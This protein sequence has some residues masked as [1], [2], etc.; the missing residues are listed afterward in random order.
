MIYLYNTLARKKQIFKPIKNKQVG[1]YTCGP[2][3]YSYAHIGNLRTYIFED[4]LKRVLFYH[5]YKVKHVMNITD[6]GHLT[7][8]ADTGEDKIEKA[9]K[10]SKKSA[11][12]IA[13]F[14]T[15]TFFTDCEKLN[16]LAPDIIAKA[17]DHIEEDIELIKELERKNFT[18]KTSDGIYF[19][20]SK[21]KDYGKLTG[22]NFTK[23]N[24]T[25]M[26]GARI[27][28]SQEKKNITDFS[29]WKFSPKNEKR[30]M[31]WKSPWGIG[32]PGWHIECSAINLKY[33]G[34]AFKGKK[35][36]LKKAQTIDIH[37]GGTDHIPIHHT[38]EIAQVEAVTNKQFVNFWLHGEFLVL[39][40][41]RMGKSE[42][43][44]I[45]IKNIEESGFSPIA[46]RYLV[47]N[48][49]YRTLLEFSEKSLKNA[50]ESLNNIYNFVL[51]CLI[52][53]KSNSLTQSNNNIK[54]KKNIDSLLNKIKK[55]FETSINDD[56]NTPKALAVFW[57]LIKNYYEFKN[58]S[59]KTSKVFLKRIYA[60]AMNFDKILGLKLDKIKLTTI[61]KKIKESAKKR[62]HL[63]ETG[64][65]AEADKIRKNIEE[66][67]FLLED[68]K[69]GT[70]IK[71]KF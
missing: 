7:S 62:E 61:P 41:V 14:Y 40:D 28:M 2:T 59:D 37:T 13:D 39:K 46:F 48:S 70:I 43:N 20:T 51:D 24:K 66:S 9:A 58:N 4:V 23:L 53:I 1:L 56:L 15:K 44:T 29:L 30:Q 19:D 49:H 10:K 3:V 27:E 57:E 68:T 22:M 69:K 31:E 65:W 32:F 50:Q 6:V 47:L 63:R 35:L 45:L 54:N 67:G 34:Q 25:L 71:P 26:A 64:K 17:T 36:F 11:F 38:N 33:L 12:E 5:A 18:Y 42:G 16:I 21:L 52:T 8:D 60:L 55:E